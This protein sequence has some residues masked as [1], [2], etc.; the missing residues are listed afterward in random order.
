MS[1]SAEQLRVCA[2]PDCGTVLSVYNPGELCSACAAKGQE[3][4]LP[5]VDID[6]KV[7]AILADAHAERPGE[8]VDVLEELRRQGIAADCWMVQSAVRRIYRRFGIH[9]TGAP[10]ASGLRN[11][12]GYL[13]SE[14]EYRFRPRNRTA[15]ASELH[16]RQEQV[17]VTTDQPPLF[18]LSDSGTG[19]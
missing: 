9:A 18:A 17:E 13:I 14:V 19:G 4:V 2:N 8:P 1:V 3:S 10:A 12:A 6:F 16:G 7:L 11:R 15:V 5:A